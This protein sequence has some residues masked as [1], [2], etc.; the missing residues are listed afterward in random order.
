MSDTKGF[1]VVSFSRD[2]GVITDAGWL[3]SRRHL[4]YGLLEID[5][6]CVRQSI[7][8]RKATGENLSFTG[9]IVKCLAQAI[10]T[11][12]MSHAFRDWLGRL[13]IFDD[14]DVVTMIETEKDGV[15]LPHIVRAANRKSFQEISAE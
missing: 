10:E 14:V 13:V 2:R 4:V 7:R 3:D 8:E 9:F 5:V 1:K 6:T 15:A 11:H 12:P